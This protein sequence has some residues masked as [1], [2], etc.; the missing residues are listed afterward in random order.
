M[1]SVSPTIENLKI[2]GQEYFNIVVHRI[3]LEDEGIEVMENEVVEFC[4][5]EKK[6][7]MLLSIDQNWSPSQIEQY[8][9]MVDSGMQECVNVVRVLYNYFFII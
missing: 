8:V 5:H 9:E 4:A 3:V 7:F 2:K 6:I 1:I